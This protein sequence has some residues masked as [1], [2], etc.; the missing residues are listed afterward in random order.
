VRRGDDRLWDI[1]RKCFWD[2]K[3][4]ASHRGLAMTKMQRFSRMGPWRQPKSRVFDYILATRQ[5]RITGSQMT[6]DP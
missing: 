4:E 3:K 6:I 2:F 5:R 1:A